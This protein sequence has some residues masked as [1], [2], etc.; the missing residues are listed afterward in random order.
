MHTETPSTAKYYWFPAKKYGWGWGAPKSW[1]G[2]VV[3]G[4]FA[5]ALLLSGFLFQPRKRPLEFAVCVLALT[6]A[7]LAIAWLKGEKPRWRW[8]EKQ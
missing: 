2:R 1:Q 3:I 8:G 5:G 7:I 6:V 4:V